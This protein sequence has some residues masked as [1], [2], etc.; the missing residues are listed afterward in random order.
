MAY[1]EAEL[2]RSRD[3]LIILLIF[4]TVW[5]AEIAAFILILWAWGVVL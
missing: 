4:L 1:S 3:P 5:F 2:R